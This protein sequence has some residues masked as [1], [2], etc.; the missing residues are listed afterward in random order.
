MTIVLRLALKDSNLTLR[1]ERVQE[2][3]LLTTQSNS[4]EVKLQDA[5]KCME[6]AGKLGMEDICC[7]IAPPALTLTL[8]TLV[9]LKDIPEMRSILSIH[10][11]VQRVLKKLINF[12]TH[13][14][15]LVLRVWVIFVLSLVQRV[16][17]DVEMSALREPAVR[18]EESKAFRLSFMAL[19]NLLSKPQLKL[20]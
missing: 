17:F 6:S 4:S 3:I 5:Q 8:P 18:M 1:T 15:M 19:K 9:T 16:I 2:S 11:V 12:A 13:N 20:I 14:V 7:L 10:W